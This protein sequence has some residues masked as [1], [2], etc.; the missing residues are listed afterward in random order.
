M[1]L[2]LIHYGKAGDAGCCFGV[3]GCLI[4]CNDGASYSA[5]LQQQ[6]RFLL[7]FEL[8]G[9]EIGTEFYSTGTCKLTGTA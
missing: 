3:V 2:L 9:Y 7:S 4:Q 1:G 8:W 5:A 6:Q